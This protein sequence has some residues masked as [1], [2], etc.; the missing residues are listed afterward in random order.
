MQGRTPDNGLG[1]DWAP[2]GQHVAYSLGGEGSPRPNE[3]VYVAAVDGSGEEQVGDPTLIGRKPTYS[4]DGATIAFT[5]SREGVGSSAAAAC[6]AATRS[7]APT[8][9]HPTVAT[10]GV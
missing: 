1:L 8:S 6:P 5:G 10:C 3:H 9:C 7:R 4:P 2:D